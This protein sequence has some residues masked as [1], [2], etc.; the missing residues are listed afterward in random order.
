MSLAAARSAVKTI[1]EQVN[2]L[3]C[4]D[5]V[6][7][8]VNPPAAVVG[9]PVGDID[10]HQNHSGGWEYRLPIQVIVAK[11]SDRHADARLEALIAAS[12]A[13]SS[14]VAALESDNQPTTS[15]DSMSVEGIGDFGIVTVNDID[16]LAC[17]VTVSIYG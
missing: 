17:T 7:D 15:V 11:V 1:L 2:G 16:Y 5:F 10:P 9:W 14:V 4:Y 12:G 3:R 6:P 13:D 8:L